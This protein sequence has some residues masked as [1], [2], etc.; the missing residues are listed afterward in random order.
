MNLPPGFTL[1]KAPTLPTVQP[2]ALPSGFTLDAPSNNLPVG[3]VLDA[4]AAA[5]LPDADSGFF[6]QALDVPTQLAKGAVT[7]TR[8]LTDVFGADNPVSQTL[9]GVEDEL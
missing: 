1:D 9:S 8:F 2:E 3:F 6:R 7:G 4:P 5:P